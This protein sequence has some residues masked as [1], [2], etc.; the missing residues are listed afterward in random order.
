MNSRSFLSM[1]RG[2]QWKHWAIRWVMQAAPRITRKAEPT[3]YESPVTPIGPSQWSSFLEPLLFLREE[4]QLTIYQKGFCASRFLMPPWGD[5][6]QFDETADSG[7]QT[8]SPHVE[9]RIMGRIYGQTGHGITSCASS[10]V[11]QQQISSKQS[12]EIIPTPSQQ[13]QR[14]VISSPSSITPPPRLLE[15]LTSNSISSSPG[16]SLTP[17]LSS[18]IHH[19]TASGSRPRSGRDAHVN[20]QRSH[21]SHNYNPPRILSSMKNS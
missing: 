19:P 15:H 3:V 4:A 18:L 7:M 17:W 11:A 20:L 12:A 5:G 9:Q 21:R 16:S 10:G 2:N 14:P 13:S 6:R 8:S 1:L